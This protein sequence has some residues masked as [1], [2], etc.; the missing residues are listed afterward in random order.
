MERR[1]H[2]SSTQ[3]EG[4]DRVWQLKGPLSGGACWQGSSQNR[5]QSTWQLLRGS[6]GSSSELVRLQASTLDNRYDVRSA[7]P[8]GTG[9]E[10][11]HFTINSYLFHRS[12]KSIRL[13]LMCA[14]L[15]STCPCWRSTLDDP[16]H[17]HVPRWYV[18]SRTAG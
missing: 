18:G 17:P 8:A 16:D 5:G 15:G 14:T 4:S 6:W 10:K 11:Q 7:Q 12:G 2:Q 9:I 13:C 1:H 3:E